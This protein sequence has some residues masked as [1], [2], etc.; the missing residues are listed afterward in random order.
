MDLLAAL[1]SLKT[2][3]WHHSCMNSENFFFKLQNL[4]FFELKHIFSTA[5][6]WFPA[7]GK[8]GFQIEKKALKERS[9]FFISKN[10]FLSSEFNKS[11]F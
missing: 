10:I 9:V 2:V 7:V 4:R 5:K 1:A 8:Q 6:N 11:F 3:T